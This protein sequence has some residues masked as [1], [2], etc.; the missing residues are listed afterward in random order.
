[1]IKINKDRLESKEYHQNTIGATH[2]LQSY[3]IMCTPQGV[4]FD[5]LLKNTKSWNIKKISRATLAEC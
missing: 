5:E 4:S 2:R 3:S 1:M